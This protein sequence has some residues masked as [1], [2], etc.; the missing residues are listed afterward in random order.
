LPTFSRFNAHRN[1]GKTLLSTAIVIL[2][3]ASIPLF[4]LQIAVSGAMPIF[5]DNFETGDFSK[6]TGIRSHNSGVSADIQTGTVYSGTYAMR[7]V[8]A[9]QASESGCCL[10][11]DLGAGYTTINARAYLYLNAIPKDGSVM[12]VMGFSSDGWIPNA[13]GTRID[14]KNVG[15]NVQWRINYY[16]GGWQSSYVGAVQAGNWYC[17]E[18]HLAIGTGNGETRFYVNGTEVLTKTGLSNTPAG[19]SVRYLSLGVND[20]AGGNT[21]NVFFNS[22]AV[23]NSYIGLEGSPSPTPPPTP[24]ASPSPSPTPS[25]SPSPSPSPT[26]S[27][28]SSPSPSPTPTASPTPTP[29]PAPTAS[30]TP[31]PTPTPSPSPIPTATPTPTP[32][33]S[34]SPTP[35]PTP[36][37]LFNDTFET[38]NTNQWTATKTYNTGITPTIQNTTTYNGTY[39][40]KLAIAD[41]AQETGWCLYKD[42]GASYT[43][44]DARIFVRLTAKPTQGS[45]LEIMGFSANG[46]LPSAVGTRVDIRNVDGTPVWRINYYD[47]GWHAATAGNITLDTWYCVIQTHHRF[48]YRRNPPLR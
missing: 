29:S 8:V 22:V 27:P 34:P 33:P 21:L 42:L 44:I 31:T 41:G 6:W 11:K 23:A 9:D 25:P 2:L 37:L 10:Y 17:I 30:P 28:S 16:N 38:A 32:T 24:T 4:A 43:A 14:I 26:P 18:V 39:A 3:L 19:G 47:N 35:T 12:E 45:T 48:W 5:T 40:L 7:L 15:G 1:R 20:E 13:A 46:W 36:T